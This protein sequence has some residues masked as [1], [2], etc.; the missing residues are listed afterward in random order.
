M[1]APD[2][3]A[4]VGHNK[5]RLVL[6]ILRRI[7]SSEIIIGRNKEKEPWRKLLAISCHLPLRRIEG[8]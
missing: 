3:L 7:D 4:S 6:L 8:G 1:S 2:K 5:W